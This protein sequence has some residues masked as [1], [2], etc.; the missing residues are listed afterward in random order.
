[1]KFLL[2]AQN[3]D[4][5]KISFDFFHV[6]MKM[7][8]CFSV[9][10][11]ADS[12]GWGFP[13]ASSPFFDSQIWQ[14]R[15]Q[16]SQVSDSFNFDQENG[17]LIECIFAPPNAVSAD[18]EAIH[19]DPEERDKKQ[20]NDQNDQQK[21]SRSDQ[22][23]IRWFRLSD[24]TEP[25]IHETKPWTIEHKSL[26]GPFSNLISINQTLHP[27]ATTLVGFFSFYYRLSVHYQITNLEN[28]LKLEKV[29]ATFWI[30]C[31]HFYQER[32]LL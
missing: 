17:I 10:L 14:I 32:H 3:L 20:H 9:T 4:R 6:W 13:A 19:E 7:L 11:L 12:D 26:P 24:H 27:F 18:N 16:S 1:M 31:L 29:F 22:I 23:R 8:L 21:L 2:S 30:I 15:Q 5:L 25:L 28:S